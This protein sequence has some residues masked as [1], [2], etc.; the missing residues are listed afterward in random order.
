MTMTTEKSKAA[1]AEAKPE[2]AKA[3]AN[4]QTVEIWPLR[5]YK[6][7]NE[8]RRRGGPSYKAPRR[9]AEALIATG[10]ATDA[11]PKE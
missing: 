5:S 3:E 6:E 2:A 10:L 9:H 11:K 7:G 8:F 4:P 1:K